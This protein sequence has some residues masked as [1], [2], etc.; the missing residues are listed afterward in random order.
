MW[1]RKNPGVKILLCC[2][3]I[4]SSSKCCFS[5]PIEVP[6]AVAL[7][8]GCCCFYMLIRI[9]CNSSCKYLF[10]INLLVINILHRLLGASLDECGFNKGEYH[11][12]TFTW[13]G[14][15]IF[16]IM[17]TM[18]VKSIKAIFQYRHTRAIHRCRQWWW[19]N[20]RLESIPV[21]HGVDIRQVMQ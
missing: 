13:N 6:V 16:I 19:R 11:I 3:F 1:R 9:G 20:C 14:I 8:V 15:F 2:L 5:P 7:A 21:H 17:M 4:N 10:P 18:F 12:I